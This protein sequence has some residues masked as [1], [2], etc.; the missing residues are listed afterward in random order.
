MPCP[1]AQG[2]GGGDYNDSAAVE[3]EEELK[4][5]AAANYGMGAQAGGKS[6]ASPMLL[7][8]LGSTGGGRLGPGPPPASPMQ[9]A[10]VVRELCVSALGPVL[11]EVRVVMRACRDA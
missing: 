8:A 6:S 4:G 10:A 9:R 11:F 3:F 5:G 2:N 7:N 1:H